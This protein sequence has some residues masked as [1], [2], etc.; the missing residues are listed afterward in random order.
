MICVTNAASGMKYLHD[1][2]ILHRDMKPEN[3]LL[4]FTGARYPAPQDITLKIGKFENNIE[5]ILI[6][7]SKD[8]LHK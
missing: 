5:H 7:S 3:V 4:S 2:E 8:D 1:R 6:R